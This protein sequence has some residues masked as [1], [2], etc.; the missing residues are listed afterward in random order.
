[1]PHCLKLKVQM[2]PELEIK[3]TERMSNFNKVF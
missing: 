2:G 3:I 1:M